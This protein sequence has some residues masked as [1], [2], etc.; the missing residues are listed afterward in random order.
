MYIDQYTRANW[1]EEYRRK[2]HFYNGLVRDYG[3]IAGYDMKIIL[4][5]ANAKI[6]NENTFKPTIGKHSMYATTYET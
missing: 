1:R 3:K 6:G 5:D 2:K 4:G